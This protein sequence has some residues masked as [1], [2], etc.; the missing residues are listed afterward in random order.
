MDQQPEDASSPPGSPE[1]ALK[2]SHNVQK[3]VNT[4]VEDPVHEDA[5]KEDDEAREED[6]R[7]HTAEDGTAEKDDTDD[8]VTLHTTSSHGIA[9][10]ED[11]SNPGL[12]LNDENEH[13]ELC[14]TL[15]IPPILHKDMSHFAKHFQ[16]QPGALISMFNWAHYFESKIG[17]AVQSVAARITDIKDAIKSAVDRVRD[18]L[19]HNFENVPQIIKQSAQEAV[20]WV[21]ENPKTTALIIVCAIGVV[22]PVVF[23]APGLAVA[24]FEAEGVAAGILCC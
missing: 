16:D 3:Y 10:E 13:D 1:M 11:E 14:N 22:A 2:S 9:G 21:K 19:G 12:Q 15:C 20:A 6:G 18:I 24:G 8:F 7:A 23:V 4:S 5:G 17:S